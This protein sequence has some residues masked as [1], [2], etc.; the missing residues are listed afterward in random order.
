[1]LGGCSDDLPWWPLDVKDEDEEKEANVTEVTE[2]DEEDKE[3]GDKE[4]EAM[5]CV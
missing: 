1:M 4:R 3:D 5:I 2:A